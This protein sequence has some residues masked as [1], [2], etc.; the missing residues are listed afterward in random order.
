M[1]WRYVQTFVPGGQK[2]PRKHYVA[3][4]ERY[5]SLCLPQRVHSWY[6]G[7]NKYNCFLSEE[8][9][10]L[11]LTWLFVTHREDETSRRD[12]KPVPHSKRKEFRR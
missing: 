3:K 12:D 6:N 4:R 10:L 1:D 7:S 8:K 2:E 11:R 9:I 5:V